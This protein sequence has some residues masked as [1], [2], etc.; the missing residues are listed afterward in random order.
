MT[1]IALIVV[2]AGKGVRLGHEEEKALLPLLGHPMLA[3]T[4]LAFDSFDAIVERVV[5]VPPGREDVFR[6]RVLAPMNFENKVSL[7]GGGEERQDSVALAMNRLSEEPHWIMVH[8]AARPLVSKGLIQRVIDS[9]EEGESVVPALPLRDSVARLGYDR[10]I[11]TY[12]DR[13]ELL[14]VQTPQ[15]FHRPV[16]EYAY[17]HAKANRHQS[18][19]EASLVL[20]VNHPVSW[21]DGEADNIKVT[22]PADRWIAESILRA[23]GYREESR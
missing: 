18:T 8:D 21:I 10:W 2:A 14:T 16:L 23:R 7:V 22:F 13:K 15:A 19:D 1:S 17:Q 9:L 6:E 12:E 5:A 11:K 3:W 4:L 20:R